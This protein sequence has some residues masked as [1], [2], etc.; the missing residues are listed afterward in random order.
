MSNTE[1]QEA[2][3]KNEKSSLDVKKSKVF[4]GGLKIKQIKLEENCK[5]KK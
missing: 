4:I 3:N 2:K 5:I 1:A